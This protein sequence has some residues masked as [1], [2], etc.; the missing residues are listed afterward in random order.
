MEEI[1][2]NSDLLLKRGEIDKKIKKRDV[3]ELFKEEKW[4]FKIKHLCFK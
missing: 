1:I 4:I 2:K 3:E